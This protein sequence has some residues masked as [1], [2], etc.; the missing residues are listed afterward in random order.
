MVNLHRDPKKQSKPV[1]PQELLELSI[2]PKKKL[3]IAPGIDVLN[4]V[5]KNIN[6]NSNG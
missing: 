2:D 1:Q 6:K 3:S 5:I 4:K